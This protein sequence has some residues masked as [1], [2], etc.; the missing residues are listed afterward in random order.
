MVPWRFT[1]FYENSFSILAYAQVIEEEGRMTKERT[2]VGDCLDN[3]G[4]KSY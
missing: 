3:I 4:K 1:S 2:T